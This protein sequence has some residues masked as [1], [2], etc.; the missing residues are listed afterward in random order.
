VGHPT[1]AR[2]ALGGHQAG[3]GRDGRPGARQ[4]VSRGGRSG[5]SRSSTPGGPCGA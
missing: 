4:P 2:R 5:S 3:A 1:G